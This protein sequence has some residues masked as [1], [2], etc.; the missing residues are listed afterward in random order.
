MT[1]KIREIVYAKYDGRCAY[2]GQQIKI[3]NMQVDHFTPQR[4]YNGK[5]GSNDLENL[6][7]SCRRCNHYKRANPLELY[8]LYL[9]ELKRKV[10]DDT[11][12]GKVAMDYGMVEWKEWD[13]KFY[14][15]KC[16]EAE[17]ALGKEQG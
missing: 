11:Y 12:L 3:E 15:E 5:A 8:R 2:C 16:A 17:K 9:L 6:M 4:P 10:L 13:G 7:P 1:K 14:F